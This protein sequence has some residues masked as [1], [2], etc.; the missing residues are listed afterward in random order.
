[1][2]AHCEVCRVVLKDPCNPHKTGETEIRQIR[3]LIKDQ[4]FA[5]CP[6]C[7]RA[8]IFTKIGIKETET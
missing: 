6:V 4:F 2:L 1:M 7:G 8:Q 3:Q 5:Y